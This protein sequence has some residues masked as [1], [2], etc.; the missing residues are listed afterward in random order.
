MGATFL[1]WQKRVRC[2]NAHIQL[3]A[4]VMPEEKGFNG[5][6]T[7]VSAWFLAL[8]DF[9]RQWYRPTFLRQIVHVSSGR[10]ISRC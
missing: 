5:L 3:H 4:E 6:K 9:E 2:A 7:Q 10:R 1:F 8:T